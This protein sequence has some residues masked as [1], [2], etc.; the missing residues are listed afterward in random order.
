VIDEYGGTAGIVTLENLIE[1][2][3]GRIEEEPPIGS[4]DTPITL[5]ADGSL[6]LDG[7]MR[8]EEFEELAGIKLPESVH[9]QVDT[10]GGL[11]MTS[12]DRIPEVGDEVQ[13][14]DRVLRVEEL[15]GRRVEA[16]RLLPAPSGLPPILDVDHE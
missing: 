7:L 10:L 14:T 11:V 9:E 2:L 6:M 5:E 16:V 15:D 8:L 3:V 4:E 12:L 13:V 1:A